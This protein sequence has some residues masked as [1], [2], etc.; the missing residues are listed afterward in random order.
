M[1]E[2]IKVAIDSSKCL[3][4]TACG[5]CLRVCPVNIFDQKND[6]P[7]IIEENEDECTL[8]ELCMEVC[9]PNALLIHKLYED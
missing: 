6:E 8:C 5:G 9:S 1:S 7:L 4:V 3:G 2:F